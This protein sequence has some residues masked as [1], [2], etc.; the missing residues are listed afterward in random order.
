M[1][2]EAADRGAARRRRAAPTRRPTSRSRTASTCCA[3]RPTA[4]TARARRPATRARCA[5]APTWSSWSTPTTSTTRRSC[6]RWSSR[7]SPAG[8]DMVIGSRL[9]EDRAIAGGMPRWKWLGN[10][11]LTGI[12]NRAFGVRFSEYHTGYRAFSA[13]AAALDRLPAQLRRV[14]LRPADLRPGHRRAARA[15]SRSRSPRATSARPRASTSS[16]SVRYARQTLWV[17][18]R[19]LADRRGARWTLLR[20]PRGGARRE[21][22]SARDE[23]APRSSARAVAPCGWSAA[24]LILVAALSCARVRRRD[25]GLRARPRRARLR[26]PRAVDRPRRGLLGH[27]RLRPA[28]GVPPAR[29]HVLRSAACTTSP[30]SSARPRPSACASARIAGAYVGTRRSSRSSGCS[31][32]S[33]GARGVA[34]VAMALAAVYVPLRHR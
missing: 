32:C 1:P 23:P 14:R 13:D 31:R 2:V 7:S 29:L 12:E 33:S 11:L 30:A 20:R 34:L 26:R 4:A 17:L 6:R 16:T 21:P 18:A 9:L 22:A 10:R 3:T 15:S 19:Y 5:T 25:A 24:A 8:A 27:A 28:D